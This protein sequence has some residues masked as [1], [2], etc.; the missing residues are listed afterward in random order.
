MALY[1]DPPP[2]RPFS[3]DKPTLL[4]CWWIT[5]FCAVIILLRVAGRFV[6]TERLFREDKMAALALIPLFAR[7]GCVHIILIYGTN[8]AQLAGVELSDE[9]LR[10]RRIGSGLVLLSRVL[11]AA[12]LWVLKNAILE[13]FRRL[14][15]TWERSYELSLVYIRIAL[16]TTFIAVVI[17]DLAECQPFSH[18]WQV[19]P[20]P[21]GKCRQGYA[22]LLTMA[23]C[24]V[25]T[26]L[27]LVICP[28]PI[29]LRS[30][31]T[32][33]R[34]L[35]LVLLFSLGLAPVGVT[36]YRVP[37]II[38][39][40]GSQQSRSLYASVELLFATAAAN[41][42]V[43]GSFVRDR[44][45]KKKKFKYES[46][47]VA[48]SIGRSSASESRRPTVLRHWGS[49]EDLVRETGYGVK[50]EL[51]EQQPSLT[52][53]P[54]YTPAPVAKLQED[55]NSWQFPGSKR[56]SVAPSD[57]NLM[58]GENPVGSVRRNS[59]RRVSFFDY[60]G[61][62]D[63]LGPTSRRASCVSTKSQS[64]PP[65]NT[66]TSTS[67]T[68]TPPAAA[69]PAGVHGLRRGSAALLQDLGGFL[70]PLTSI[71]SATKPKPP[72][73]KSGSTEL[74]PIEQSQL[75]GSNSPPLRP[76]TDHQ[77]EKQKLE[78]LDAG[79]LLSGEKKE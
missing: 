13:F 29:I 67:T 52:E 51:R 8:N 26:D 12:T 62:L 78:L 3:N 63:D 72:R 46:V 37:H 44:G 45:V 10:R 54:V 31:M 35:Q 76:A 43:L 1:S 2:L 77:S 15:V 16:V 42:L 61:L 4:V 28:I 56:D 68:M 53:N 74:E 7:M 9:E 66:T 49:D 23:V 11:Y 32:T 25:L 79:G 22:Q 64:S 71:H 20:D 33:K 27:L 5:M 30:T 17:S 59:A 57:D 6:R 70:S 41:T 19:L 39:E 48:S 21:G 24:N 65:S 75:E 60:G 55:M 47:A 38:S 50:P 14:N 36:I 18:Y 69:V 58:L 34:K 73:T 40:G